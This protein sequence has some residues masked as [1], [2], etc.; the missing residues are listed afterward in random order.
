[1][2]STPPGREPV[3]GPGAPRPPRPGVAG[4]PTMLTVA[5]ALVLVEAT[6]LA[7]AVVAGVVA[8]VQGGDVAPVLFL[9]TLALGTAVLLVHAARALWSGRRWGRAPVVTAQ[10]FL[11]VTAATWWASGGGAW[12]ALPGVVALVVVVAVLSPRVVAVTSGGRE[13]GA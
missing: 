1:M 3:T 4:R 8:L 6:A 7:V 5:C 13:P 9:C 11:L 10:V 12:A 2:R